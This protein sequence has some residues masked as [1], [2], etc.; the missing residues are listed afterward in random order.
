MPLGIVNEKA[1]PLPRG[2]GL[3]VIMDRCM[4]I[5]FARLVGS[6]RWVG[7]DAR[8][9]MKGVKILLVA[10]LLLG[11]C[12]NG[13]AQKEPLSLPA[14]PLTDEYYQAFRGFYYDSF[15]MIFEVIGNDTVALPLE[16]F[17][18]LSLEAQINVC[19]VGMDYVVFYVPMIG[20]IIKILK[21]RDRGILV[22]KIFADESGISWDFERELSD[23]EKDKIRQRMALFRDEF[24][25]G[26]GHIRNKTRYCLDNRLVSKS[27]ARASKFI[28]V[29][30]SVPMEFQVRDIYRSQVPLIRW[31]QTNIP[32]SEERDFLQTMVE[33]MDRKY[34]VF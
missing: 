11:I 32:E 18:K 17:S 33:S 15:H 20:A 29:Y 6:L 23:G 5:V 24:K 1:A 22:V 14:D 26:M 7:V 25:L 28:E 4:K 30:A 19:L 34:S 8:A 3:E 27:L 16:D 31:I 10:L 12:S 2:A 13:Y 9:I 21:K